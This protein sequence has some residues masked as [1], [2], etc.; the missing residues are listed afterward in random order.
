MHGAGSAGEKVC[1]IYSDKSILSFAE[2]GVLFS[3]P[4]LNSSSSAGQ[5]SQICRW[6]FQ[7]WTAQVSDR[8]RP[9]CLARM[10]RRVGRI[11]VGITRDRRLHG[12]AQDNFDSKA[13]PAEMSLASDRKLQTKIA[14]ANPKRVAA[15]PRAAAVK[16]ETAVVDVMRFHDPVRSGKIF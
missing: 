5:H 8:V 12:G 15:R 4:E 9:H 7:C 3:P 14:V 16:F 10:N 2:C 13:R 6:V 11:F 1:E